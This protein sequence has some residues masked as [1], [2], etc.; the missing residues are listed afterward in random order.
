MPAK[1][2]EALAQKF[3][4]SID[5]AERIWNEAKESCKKQYGYREESTELYQC[6][7]GITR[8]RLEMRKDSKFDI[9]QQLDRHKLSRIYIENLHP[10]LSGIQVYVDGQSIVYI[11]PEELYKIMEVSS[12]GDKITEKQLD[13]LERKSKKKIIVKEKKPKVKKMAD[14]FMRRF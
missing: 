12:F 5:R 4:V 6:A 9:I 14:T 3:G 8:K 1:G 2:L 10:E 7:M 11:V 13:L